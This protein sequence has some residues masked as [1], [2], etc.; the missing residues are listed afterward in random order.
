M[1]MRESVSKSRRMSV[2]GSNSKS[3]HIQTKRQKLPK[4]FP[5]EI[6]LHDI[7][8]EDKFCDCGC[9]KTKMGEEISEQLDVIPPSFKVIRHVRP[10][11]A[12]KQCQI[13]VSIAPMPKLLLPK[14]IAAPGLIAYTITAKYCDHLP[15]Y[16]QEHIW[17][18][19]G[20]AIPR[21]TLCGWIMKTANLC[22]PLWHLLGEHILSGNYIQADE[23]PVQVLKE[24]DRTNQQKSYMWVYRGGS[25]KQKAVYFDYQETRAGC[26]ARE[27]LKDF[28]GY[29]QTDGYKGYDWVDN[30]SNLIHLACMAHARRPFAELV[31]LSKKA[32]KSHEAIKLIGELYRIEDESRD[33]SAKDRFEI[34]RQHAIPILNKIE[35][36]LE[37]SIEKTPPKGKLGKTI[38][39]MRDRWKQLNHYLLDGE[40]KIDN[41]DIEN[42][43]RLFAQ[44]K[45]NWLFKG[46]PRGA[47]AGAIFY[48]LIKTAKANQLEPYQY[49]RYMLNKLPLCQSR[50]DYLD[51]SNGFLSQ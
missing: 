2:I 6:I 11:Y 13:G 14:A 37:K 38:Q 29:L 22:E 3:G 10:K 51:P 1:L 20:V 47:K 24:P 8:A 32:G 27:F 5:R 19:Y 43:I 33:L 39:Y 50:E 35:I 31:K 18:R 49:L 48:S 15:L 21:N 4:H 46:S 23:S 9:E 16:R 41:N 17:Q 30:H 45:R 44:G 36:W 42:D 12:C 26:H 25:S 7:A 28:K 40:L 34:R